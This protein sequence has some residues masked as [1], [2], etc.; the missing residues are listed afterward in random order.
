MINSTL[1]LV[2]INM[3][4]RMLAAH[5]YIQPRESRDHKK[6]P[7][8]I[9][10]HHQD[11]DWLWFSLWSLQVLEKKMCE[12]VYF[13]TLFLPWK[14]RYP[15]R[16]HPQGFRRKQCIEAA[17]SPSGEWSLW[18]CGDDLIWSSGQAPRSHLWLCFTYF[19]SSTA[20]LVLPPFDFE[21][22]HFE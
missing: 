4:K 3:E 16:R 17:G 19:C 21:F 8:L 5:K 7:Q 6:L 11:H 9:K 13:C 15:F 10:Y 18:S 1:P 22:E 12:R 14:W 2:F 20:G